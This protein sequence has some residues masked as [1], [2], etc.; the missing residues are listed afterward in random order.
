MGGSYQQMMILETT[1][2]AAA[3]ALAGH[4]GWI[5]AEGD[6]VVLF[7][8]DAGDPLRHDLPR[9]VS[10]SVDSPIVRCSIFDDEVLTV[11]VWRQG[12]FLADATTHDTAE[13]MG[14][15]PEELE[16]LE[17]VDFSALGFEAAEASGAEAFVST[18]GR[19]DQAAAVAA[20]S[21]A[22]HTY[23]PEPQEQLLL[24]L[25]LPTFAIG[26]D[27]GYLRYWEGHDDRYNGPEL[28]KIP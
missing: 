12:R 15:S 2:D 6:V 25:N 7:L 21:N 18:I 14:L 27:Y 28:R 9:A 22:Q 26:Y 1:L 3:A 4:K 20:L 8:D 16:G 10:E 19:G 13:Y 11:E 23:H 24:A 17:D 5:A